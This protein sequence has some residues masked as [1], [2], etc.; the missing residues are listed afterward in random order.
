MD[1]F[2]RSFWKELNLPCQQFSPISTIKYKSAAIV[3]SSWQIDTRQEPAAEVQ[4]FQQLDT[5][6]KPAATVQPWR[7]HKACQ[8]AHGHRRGKKLQE[9]HKQFFGKFL[10][11]TMSPKVQLSNTCVSL[12]KNSEAEPMAT[13]LSAHLSLSVGSYTPSSLVLSAGCCIQESFHLCLLQENIVSHVCFSKTSF[14]LCV[15][16]KTSFD[17]ND[18]PKKLD[19]STSLLL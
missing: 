8:Q 16:G 5:R 10:L 6:H 2:S 17:I 19:V 15:P 7:N 3:Q 11:M 1:L 4:S 9:P 18:F 14:H 13:M 12:V